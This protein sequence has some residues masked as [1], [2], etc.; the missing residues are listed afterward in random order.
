MSPKACPPPS[1]AP[2]FEGSLPSCFAA[3]RGVHPY[4][5]APVQWK[6]ASRLRFRVAISE[7]ELNPFFLQDF[8][9]FGSVN[10]EIASDWD[11]AILV[12]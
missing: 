9:R 4:L 5:S 7:P 1:G 10:T 2:F 8:W 3:L 6:A 12:R 11:C